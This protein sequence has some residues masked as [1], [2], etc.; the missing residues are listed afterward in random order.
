MQSLTSALTPKDARIGKESEIK[1]KEGLHDE[2]EGRFLKN[3]M[4]Y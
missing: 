1:I 3:L 4:W 2:C